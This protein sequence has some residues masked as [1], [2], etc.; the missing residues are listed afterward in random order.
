MTLKTQLGDG[1]EL[2]LTPE[3]AAEDPEAALNKALEFPSEGGSRRR[4]T[5]RRVSSRRSCSTGRSPVCPTLGA[6]LLV[7]VGETDDGQAVAAAVPAH[8]EGVSVESV[9][10]YYAIHPLAHHRPSST[11]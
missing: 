2:V 10:R 6:Q 11:S 3:L 9:V 7:A 1:V 8:V 5:L 4:K